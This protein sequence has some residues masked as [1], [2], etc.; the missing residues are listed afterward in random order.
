MSKRE[1]SLLIEEMVVASGDWRRVIVAR[2]E[3]GQ[4]SMRDVGK[5]T[6]RGSMN[7][8]MVCK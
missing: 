7:A 6:G 8:A 5:H 1:P 3:A 2:F 4:I